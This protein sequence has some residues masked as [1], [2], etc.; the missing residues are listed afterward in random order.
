MSS[1]SPQDYK[2]AAYL[3]TA[4]GSWWAKPRFDARFI[5]VN[6]TGHFSLSVL[7]SH[8]SDPF[9]SDIILFAVPVA[10]SPD[11]LEDG[12]NCGLCYT[13]ATSAHCLPQMQLGLSYA[14][15]PRREVP[16]TF[17]FS[18]YKWIA[19]ECSEPCSPGMHIFNPQNV[20][21]GADGALRFAT[22]EEADGSWS[23]AEAHMVEVRMIALAIRD[24][25]NVNVS[26][27]SVTVGVSMC[28]HS[29]PFIFS[30]FSSRSAATG[31]RNICVSDEQHPPE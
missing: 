9:A 24:V 25:W 30:F 10:L 26:V 14:I 20:N 2:I 5:S 17:M 19:K 8:C 21:L 18:G 1:G 11:L 13:A 23:S 22:R 12:H 27:V 31:I 29:R 15:V 4:D 28:Y 7:F 16:N 3:R 6:Q